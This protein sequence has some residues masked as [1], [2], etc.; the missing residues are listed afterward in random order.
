MGASERNLRR[1]LLSLEA[2]KVQQ[3]PFTDT[4][5]VAAPD[6]ERY[7]KVS[8]GGQ[9]CMGTRDYRALWRKLL[10]LCG[11]ELALSACD[12]PMLV[13]QAGSVAAP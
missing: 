5:E 9:V 2:C 13:G 6:W 3:Y 8:T 10:S 11:E 4:Q 7:I 1:A 12:A